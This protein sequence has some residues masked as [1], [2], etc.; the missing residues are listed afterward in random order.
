M[1][2]LLC[3][4][5]LTAV[6]PLS[7]E[8]LLEKITT[9]FD[10]ISQQGPDEYNEYRRSLR[11]HLYYNVPSILISILDL[12]NHHDQMI[13]DYL[14]EF[15]QYH[16]WVEMNKLLP[17]RVA[18]KYQKEVALNIVMFHTFFFTLN[19]DTA[20]STNASDSKEKEESKT[21]EKI[22]KIYW[23]IQFVNPLTMPKMLEMNE[24]Q[25]MLAQTERPLIMPEI[26]RIRKELNALN[27]EV[28]KL[29]LSQETKKEIS[30]TKSISDYRKLLWNII[31]NEYLP[32]ETNLFE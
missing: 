30:Q 18:E 24:L 20:E 28:A 32:K 23:L 21:S 29:D 27:T 16:I 22:L 12:E 26:H 4:F 7:K 13:Y 14:L 25:P 3:V 1:K 17:S 19:A 6:A 11:N 31:N 10:Q 5:A 15:F 9:K 8:E 2:W